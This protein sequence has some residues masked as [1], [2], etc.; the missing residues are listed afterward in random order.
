[1]SELVRWASNLPGKEH[2]GKFK[3][4]NS[5]RASPP[6]EPQV[7]ALDRDLIPFMNG[8]AN[9]GA[10]PRFPTGERASPQSDH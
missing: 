8:I 9:G 4:D 3:F 5:M 6:Y 1:M 7:A 2:A 10:G